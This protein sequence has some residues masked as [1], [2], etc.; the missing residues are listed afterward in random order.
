[1]AKHEAKLYEQ[2]Y[3]AWTQHQAAALRDLATARWNGP[4]DLDHLASE[5]QAS[6]S[7]QH[8]AAASHLTR[9]IEHLLK[10]AT[11]PSLA[12]RRR[13]R[14][15]VRRSRSELHRR[16]GLTLR[17]KLE[18][19]LADTYADAREAAAVGLLQHGEDAAAALPETR[20]WT[21]EEMLERGWYPGEG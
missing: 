5:V 6:G 9:L 3:Y 14:L 4:L 11:S 13:W 8:A 2:D 1:M 12:P 16:L 15:S 17:N 20:P 7:E 18:A 21:M 19:E 10:L